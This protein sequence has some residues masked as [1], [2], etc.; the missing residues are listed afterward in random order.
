MIIKVLTELE[1]NI[2]DTRESIFVEI[3]ELK[4]NQ[5]WIKRAINEMQ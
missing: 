2:G 5:V 4:S 3:K 1:K